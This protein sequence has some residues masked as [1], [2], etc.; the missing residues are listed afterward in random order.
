M[1]EIAK[2]L[3]LL[4]ETE[5]IVKELPRTAVAEVGEVV[6]LHSKREILQLTIVRYFGV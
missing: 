6:D 4:G 2:D 3:A 5:E 1:E